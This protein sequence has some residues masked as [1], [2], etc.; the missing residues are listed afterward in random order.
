MIM[1]YFGLTETKLLHFHRIF[2]KRGW[3]G[4]LLETPESTLDLPLHL[5]SLMGQGFN[6]SS[7]GRFRIGSDCVDAQTE[8]NIRC[9][10]MPTCTSC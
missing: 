5:C 6:D 3:G 10:H 8:L 7:D 9:T 4:G 2:Q 1:K